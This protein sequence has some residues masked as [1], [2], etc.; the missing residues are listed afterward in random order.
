MKK[1][2]AGSIP[3]DLA[4]LLKPAAPASSGAS[5]SAPSSMPDFALRPGT[6]RPNNF[7]IQT[8]PGLDEWLKRQNLCFGA[9]TYQTGQV[10]I[11][12]RQPD[13]SLMYTVRTYEHAMGIARSGEDLHLATLYQIWHFHNRVALGAPTKPPYDAVYIPRSSHVTGRMSIHDLVVEESG[14]LLF[15]NTAYS[16]VGELVPNHS[17]RPYWI[18]DWIS[19][20]APEDRCHLNGMGSRDGKARYVTAVSRTDTAAGWRAVRAKAGVVWDIVENRLVVDGLSMPH[21]PRWH[22]GALWFINSGSGFLCRT[23]PDSGGLEEVAFIPGFARGLALTGN[24]ALVGTS[25]Q[26]ANR[27]FTDLALDGNLKSRGITPQCAIHIINLTT[28]QI[29]HQV[30]FTGDIE[31]IY[32]VCVFPE[33]RLANIIGF[34][35]DD[36]REMIDIAPQP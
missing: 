8:S 17:F 14:R 6:L 21:S 36:V 23:E 18:P 32:D 25:R 34:M 3:S 28:G 5:P 10:I 19:A 29:E 33:K 7:Q 16:C 27:I 9:T 20:L 35:N 4:A 12:G 22:N 30:I 31:E 11:I 24:Y 13:D 1:K 15:V 2:L 26:R